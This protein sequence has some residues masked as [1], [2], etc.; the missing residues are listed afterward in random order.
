MPSH[1]ASSHCASP[2]VGGSL[3]RISGYC[4]HALPSCIVPGKPAWLSSSSII[5]GRGVV[6]ASAHQARPSM[7]ASDLFV[8]SLKAEGVEYA[9]GIP[10]EEK[11][12]FAR[13]T[14][15]LENPP[16]SHAS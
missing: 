8:K 3:P 5:T 14:P 2:L 11:S 4:C 15:P 6:P 1:S 16:H 12:R 7:K 13:V 9:F 10:G